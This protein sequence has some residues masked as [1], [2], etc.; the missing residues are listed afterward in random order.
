[1]MKFLL[2]VCVA[3][4][5]AAC[6]KGPESPR[7]FSLPEGDLEKGEQVFNKYACQSCHKLKGYESTVSE[8]E[9]EVPI[10]LGGSEPRAKTYADLL[11]SI[12][13]PSH[14]LAG[15]Y[16]KEQVTDS[17]G[18]SKMRN[19]ND[20]MTVSELIDLVT[21]LE[22]YYELVAYPETKYRMYYP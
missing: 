6:T 1:M 18:Q 12:I 9:L 2:L 15:G 22:S 3:L 11:T 10:L 19:Y 20:V 16:S 13:N 4:V 17:A 21:F 5:V 14:K 8:R 7:G